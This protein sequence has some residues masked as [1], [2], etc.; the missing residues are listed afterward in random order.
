RYRAG[1]IGR[2]LKD[3]GIVRNRQKIEAAVRNA[4]AFLEL[5]ESAGSFD[6]FV[7]AFVGGA[8]KHNAWKTLRQIPART[9][10]SDRLSRALQERDRKSTR[11][12]SRH[13]AISYAGFCLKKK[14]GGQ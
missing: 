3:P 12:N 8:T 13:V 2:L 1:T 14:T 7:W 9:K 6:A 11:L 5:R 4:R 10:E